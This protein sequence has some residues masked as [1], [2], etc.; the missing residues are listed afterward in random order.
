MSCMSSCIHIHMSKQLYAYTGAMTRVVGSRSPT[1]VCGQLYFPTLNCLDFLVC[2]GNC[3]TTDTFTVIVI[4][5]MGACI[6]M[7]L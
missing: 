3:F 1:Q 7:C 4:F 6:Q 2:M 5:F